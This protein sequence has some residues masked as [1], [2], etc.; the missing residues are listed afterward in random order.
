MKTLL[1]GVLF[2]LSVIWFPASSFAAVEYHA[3]A[4]PAKA[5]AYNNLI[6][7]LRCLVCQNQTIADSNADLAKD[8]RQQVHDMLQQGKTE[9]DVA[10]FMTQRYG[11]FVLYRPAFKGKTLVLWLAPVAFLLVGLATIVVLLRNKKR[12]QPTDPDARQQAELDALLRKA[13]EP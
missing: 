1:A 3:F 10:D 2:W 6:N 5:Q 11:D 13:D 8:L 12:T 7:E 4:D 9:Q